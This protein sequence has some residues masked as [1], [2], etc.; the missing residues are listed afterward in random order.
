MKK[1]AP[2]PSALR[3]SS[4]RRRTTACIS[5]IMLLVF[6]LFGGERSLRADDAEWTVLLEPM[7]MDAYGHDQ[8]VLTIQE[9]NLDSTLTEISQTPVTL[10]TEERVGFRFELQ[11]VRGDWGLGLDFFW[12]N[13]SQ[14]RPSRTAAASG[15]AG[16]VDEV[17]FQAAGRSF[18]SGD[19]GEVLFFNVIE[20]TDIATWTVDLYA[21]KTMTETPA[22]SVQ[23][24]FGLRNADFDNDYHSAAGIQN[25]AGSLF[26]AS[27]N[28]GRM[29]GP[30]VGVIGDVHFGKHSI[31][32]YFGQSVVLGT[33]ESLSH[34]TRDFVGPISATP[35]ITAREFFGKEQDVAIPITEFRISWLYPISQRI[36]L[37]LSAN[38]SVWWDVPVPP[39][40]IPSAGS[41]S[42]NENTL[43]YFGLAVA[44]KVKI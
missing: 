22:G 35:T 27:S 3:A 10:E 25:V 11:Y 36:R 39:G 29:I 18:T 23:L 13:T 8:H 15:P 19:P 14:G 43:V 5:R 16:A 31:R 26:D 38:T 12:F 6:L 9:I 1:A 21:L 44:V 24:Q 20:D 2:R 34:E 33:A 30:L 42:F 4:S 41:E 37:G 28:Y 7:Y 40:V 32:A 17:T